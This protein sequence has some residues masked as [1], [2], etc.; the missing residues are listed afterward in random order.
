MSRKKYLKDWRETNQ[1]MNE[2]LNLDITNKV[3]MLSEQEIN[4]LP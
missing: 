2:F 3:D 4:L 1:A